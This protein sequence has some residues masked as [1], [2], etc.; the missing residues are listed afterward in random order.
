MMCLTLS[1]AQLYKTIKKKK[2]MI[3]YN[4]QYGLKI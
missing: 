2:L 1:M 3:E 4:T